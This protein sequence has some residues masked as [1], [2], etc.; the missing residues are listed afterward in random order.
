MNRLIR[1]QKDHPLRPINWRWE[2]A[3]L[4]KELGKRTPGRGKDDHWVL[5]ALRLQHSLDTAKDEIDRYAAFERAGPLGLAYDVWDGEELKKNDDRPQVYNGSRVEL[6]ARLLATQ[7][8]LEIGHTLAMPKEAIEVYEAV[9]FNVIDRLDNVSYINNHA[10][11]GKMHARLTEKDFSVILKAFA[12]YS[13]S[14]ALVD[15][16][17]TTFADARATKVGDDIHQ[18]LASD[19]RW[20]M[21]RKGSLAARMIGLNDISNAQIME[22]LVRMAEADS[23]A[24]GGPASG[25]PIMDGIKTMME[26]MPISL[27]KPPDKK[28]IEHKSAELRADEE[29]RV[30]AGEVVTIENDSRNFKFPDKAEEATNP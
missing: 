9:F 6:E 28:I 27:I 18:F 13:R 16:L 21:T 15:A 30:A 26:R 29:L 23:A 25:N 7:S 14:P 5:A 24:G 10:F 22:L 11:G 2:R 19:A 17:V 8:P 4:L 3:R 20:T 1:Y 12:Y